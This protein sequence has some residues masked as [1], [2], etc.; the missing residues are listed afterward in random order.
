M[1]TFMD[2]DFKNQLFLGQR[3]IWWVQQTKISSHSWCRCAQTLNSS[4]LSMFIIIF[5]ISLDNIAFK[6]ELPIH[7]SREAVHKGGRIWTDTKFFLALTMLG[8]QGHTS[9]VLATGSQ[10][11]FPPKCHR[12]AYQ[13]CIPAYQWPFWGTCETSNTRAP[14]AWMCTKA[15]HFPLWTSPCQ[16]PLSTCPSTFTACFNPNQFEQYKF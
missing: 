9:S 15:R 16:Q 7:S 10:H 1:A 8:D 13:G 2:K 12:M 3:K 6:A 11:S 5:I 4:S 14:W